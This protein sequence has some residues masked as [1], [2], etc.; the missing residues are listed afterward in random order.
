MRLPPFGFG[1][2]PIGNLFTAVGDEE[3]RAAVDA[4]WEAGIRYYDTAPHYGLGLSERRLGEALR[5]RSGY[6]LSTKVGRRLVPGPL[7]RDSEGFDV[8]AGLRRVWDFSRDGVLRSLE[9]SLVR[10]GLDRVDLVLVHDPDE[11]MDQ[12]LREAYP[13]LASLRD[14]G[15]V[16]AVGVGVNQWQAPLRFVRE[17]DVDVVLLANRYTLLDRSGLP[18]LEA[19]AERG[20]QVIAAG[21]FNSGLLATDTPSGTFDYAPAPQPLVE[22]ARAL[23]AACA[24]HGVSL[25]QAAMAFPLRHPA[26]TSVLVGARSAAEVRRNAEL[27]RRP[28]PDTL[29]A[30]LAEAAHAGTKIQP[31]P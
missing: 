16:R 26:V 25:P 15:V 19:C 24:R 6:V 13:A 31:S 1:A 8:V 2:A 5:G 10:L 22:R 30:D 27:W 28:V 9:E 12:A 14:Q 17:T 23:A 29:W 11:H 18:L 20:V 7:A 4:A 21:V 3:A